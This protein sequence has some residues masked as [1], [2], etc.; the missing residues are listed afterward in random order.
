M[1]TSTSKKVLVARF[2]RETLPGFVN[3]Q[4]WLSPDGLELLTTSG[5][6]VMVPYA[7][8]KTVSFVR[9]FL[10]DE[11]RR[12]ARLFASRPKMGGLWIRFRFR[13]GDVMDGILPNN[14]VQIESQGYSIVPPDPGFQ[15]Q[16]VFIPKTA[17]SEALVLGVV[18]NP[19]RAEKKK[20]PQK[21]QIELFSQ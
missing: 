2:D 4:T 12:D 16:R 10:Q 19:L 3:P 15:N 21:G 8:I 18:G 20:A 5:T 7:E 6:L 11:P 1:G 14:L 17:L 9:A 13:D